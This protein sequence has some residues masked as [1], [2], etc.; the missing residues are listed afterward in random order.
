MLPSA[1]PIHQIFES[2]LTFKYTLMKT[3]ENEETMK[4]KKGVRIMK[5]ETI[6][7][8]NN[9]SMKKIMI[10]LMLASAVMTNVFGSEDKV[11]PQ[12][13]QAFNSKFQKA[14]TITWTAAGN[15]YQAS[16]NYSGNWMYARYTKDGK[17]ISVTRNVNSAELPFYLQNSIKNRHAGYWIS[18]V[19][20]ESNKSGFTYYITLEN[21]DQ[22][23]VLK[24]KSGSDWV[25]NQKSD[26]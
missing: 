17:F 5:Q 11:S 16:F 3:I 26:K 23:I 8:Q 25:L 21:A 12:V 19:V 13:L 24:S 2:I 6:T 9:L 14:H 18:D 7:K 4:Q 1:I 20:E 15:Y 22:K 10:T